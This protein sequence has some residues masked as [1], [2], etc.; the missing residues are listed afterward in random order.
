MSQRRIVIFDSNAVIHRA[1]HALPPFTLKNGTPIN[2]VYGYATVFFKVLETLKPDY[3]FAAFDVSGGSF[4]NEQ[5][6]QYKANRVKADQ[7][8]YQQIPLVQDLMTGFQV[9]IIKQEGY[10]ADDLIGTLAQI[11]GQDPDKEIIIVTGDMDC[12]QLITDNVFVYRL[13]KGVSDTVLVDSKTVQETYGVTPRQII[14]LKGLQGDTSDNIPG[15]P[16]VGPKRAQTLLGRFHHVEGVYAFL[17]DYQ[18]FTDIPKDQR[19]GLTKSLFGNLKENQDQAFLSKQLATIYTEVDLELSLPEPYT[20][21]LKQGKETLRTFE[22]YSLIKRLSSEQLQAPSGQGTLLS[23][24][25]KT[26]EPRPSVATIEELQSPVHIWPQKDSVTLADPD[27]TYNASWAEIEH[28]L[29]SATHCV[30]AGVKSWMRQMNID[31]RTFQ[32]EIDDVEIMRYLLQPGD[33]DYDLETLCLT[34]GLSYDPEEPDRVLTHLYHI[35]QKHLETKHLTPLYTTIERPLIPILAEMEK[36]G[37]FLD[38]KTLEE[39]N[40]K[41]SEQI[42]SLEQSIYS[43]AGTEFNINSPKQ[44][45]EILFERLEIPSKGLKRTSS[46]QISTSAQVLEELAS[47]YSIVSHILSYRELAKLK[48]TYIDSLPYLRDDQDRIHTTYQQ[49]IT[50][51]G[52]LSSTNPNLQNIPV[53]SELGRD[54]RKCFRAPQG[55]KF[56]ACDYSQIELRLAAHLSQDHNLMTVFTENQDVHTATAQGIYQVSQEEITKEMRSFAKTIN[57]GILYGMGAYALSR[58]LGISYA[59]A[60]HMLEQYR[61]TYPELHTYIEQQQAFAKE[62][63]YAQTE[64]GRIRDLSQYE[65]RRQQAELERI[66]VNMPIQGLQ[67]DII[68]KAMITIDD[69]LRRA[70][71]IHMI[72]QVHDELIFEVKEDHI[73]DYQ[74]QIIDLMQSVYSASVPLQVEAHISDT[75]GG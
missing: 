63:K 48:S 5:F 71:D 44:L 54:I 59:E 17:D 62:H 4:R 52:R 65:G 29:T 68:K 43:Q 30:G 8:L 64:F 39:I 22:F 10:E 1:Y 40:Q 19:T 73:E 36:H 9:P 28:L 13:K 56:L 23:S 14:D 50:A 33:R 7:E 32:A 25:V 53:R 46:G 21:P 35:L 20:F 42:T 18:E 15:V 66:A 2:A 60:Q 27:H 26:F 49:T 37:V 12:M 58:N 45:S 6:A 67:A 55:W 16:G 72:L 75:W 38:V 57:F 41:V 11:F 24:S 69:Y 74:D 61:Q 70:D 3:L 51:T 47:T 34:Y 31:T